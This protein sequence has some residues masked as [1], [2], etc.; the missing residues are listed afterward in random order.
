MRALNR[1]SRNASCRTRRLDDSYMSMLDERD[2]RSAEGAPVSGAPTRSLRSLYLV[3]LQVNLGTSWHPFD[4]PPHSSDEQDYLLRIIRQAG[5]ALARLRARL[6]GGASAP[7]VRRHTDTAIGALLGRESVVLA[8]LD[9]ES[10]ARLAGHPASVALWIALLDVDAEAAA[11][12]DDMAGAEV[13]RARALALRAAA[14]RIWS[15]DVPRQ[16]PTATTDVVDHD[17]AQPG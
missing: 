12:A 9:P 11:A 4:M 7:E 17:P 3:R 13:V 5:E 8:R 16:L 15:M 1:K 6:A 14:D 2:R 10:A